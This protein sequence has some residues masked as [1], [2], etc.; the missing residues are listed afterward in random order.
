MKVGI[1]GFGNMGQAIYEKLKNEQNEALFYVNEKDSNKLKGKIKNNELDEELELDYI[2]LSVKPKDIAKLKKLKWK[3]V[4]ISIAAGVPIKK[5]KDE[6]PNYKILRIMPNTPLLVNEGISG[7]FMDPELLKEEQ[8]KALYFLSFFTKTVVVE[9]EQMID[10]ITAVS[11]CGPAFVYLFIEAMADAAVKLGINRKDAYN[12]VSQ[13]VLGAGKMVMETGKHPGE[14]KD[15]VTSPGGSTI[16][17]VIAL[18]NNGLRNS[19]IKAVEAAY[20]KT[21]KV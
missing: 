5:L 10:S 16:E 17:G 3:G 18:E 1:I 8:E 21:I 12:L 6:F 4:I 19:I 14:L 2:I 13:T 20:M 11:G 15:M 9:S 7:V